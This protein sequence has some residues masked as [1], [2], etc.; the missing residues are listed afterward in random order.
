MIGGVISQI[1]ERLYLPDWT[2]ALQ[3]PFRDKLVINEDE[4]SHQTLL[5]RQKNFRALNSPALLL[6]FE[7]RWRFMI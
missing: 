4:A 6:Y 3:T 2:Q 5:M 1:S 7:M